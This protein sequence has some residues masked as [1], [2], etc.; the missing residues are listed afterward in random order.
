MRA[1]P[2]SSAEGVRAGLRG[3]DLGRRNGG[4]RKYT[5]Y[6]GHHLSG[7]PRGGAFPGVFGVK[8]LGLQRLGASVRF[9]PGMRR[10]PS[11]AGCGRRARG[12]V[13]CRNSPRRS[14]AGARAALPAQLAPSVGQR[15]CHGSDTEPLPCTSAPPPLP[16][17]SWLAPPHS[18]PWA[19]PSTRSREWRRELAGLQGDATY[20]TQALEAA[21]QIG[22]PPLP[23]IRVNCKAGRR[24][25]GAVTHRMPQSLTSSPLVSASPLLGPE[26]GA[27]HVKGATG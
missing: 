5:T 25:A 2:T 1:V 6:R 4:P 27:P 8:G 11:K 9:G 13:A 16:P 12:C 17:Q 14:A 10:T 26:R 22:K 18:G 15:H 21:S 7:T 24:F 3:A 19:H 23:T 20:V